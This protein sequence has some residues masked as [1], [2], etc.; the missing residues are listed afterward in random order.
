MG[1]KLLDD[2]DHQ[3]LDRQGVSSKPTNYPEEKK[4]SE[5]LQLM[6]EQFNSK[7]FGKEKDGGFKSAIEQIKKGFNDKDFYPSTEEKAANL[8][9]LI[10]KNHAFIDGNKRIAAACFLLFLKENNILK[11]STDQP[12]ISNEALAGIT[13]FVASSKAEEKESV[14]NL[15]VSILNRNQS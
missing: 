4:Y 2:Y 6:R 3:A 7:I 10:V 5:I 12:L 14:V 1:L 9:Y 15:I 13:L 8:L 11:N